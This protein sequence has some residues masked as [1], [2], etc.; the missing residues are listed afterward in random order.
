MWDEAE[1]AS[2]GRSVLR[3]EGFA[4]A[5]VP[6]RLRPPFLPTAGAA[7]MWLFGGESDDAILRG[8][9][10]VLAL[11]V[12][13]SVYAFGAARFDKL[14]GLVAAFLLGVTPFFWTRVP[15]FL[16]EIP[17]L[18]FFAAAV[19]LFYSG[20]YLDQRHFLWSWIACAFAFLT[21]HTAVLF[22]PIVFLFVLIAWWRGGAEVRGRIRSRSF[23]LSPLAG[24]LVFLPWLAR[25]YIAFGDPLA[26]LKR[27]SHQLQ[28][29]LPG[30]AM[31]W[32]F[33]LRHLPS[34]LSLEIGLFVLV[35]IGWALWKRHRFLLHSLLAAAFIVAWFSFYRYKEDR[36][37][38]S[39][40]P[41]LTMIAAVALTKSTARLRPAARGLVLGALLAGTFVV[42]LRVTRHVFENGTTLGYPFFLDAMTFLRE[43]A[44]SGATVLGAN[45]PQIFWYTGL[46][47]VDI[48]EEVELAQALRK[49]EWIVISNFEP[50]Q[51]GYVFPMLKLISATPSSDSAVF[52]D[53][54]CVTAVV[55]SEK[56]LQTL[57]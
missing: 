29:Y 5:G 22:F 14:T 45:V 44:T 51:K 46:H 28:D 50:A 53:Q 54:R 3:G 23:F 13:L 21:R 36:I 24:L 18:G 32:D 41:F 27:A 34:L 48:P 16:C 10:A 52:W 25:E 7:A 20:L 26:G 6:N 17:F 31:P 12:L 30:T 1:Y 39:A 47:A 55:R 8:T 43:H 15:M 11:F 9:T 38:S 40:F 49:S 35:G 33:Y 57:K 42:N 2:I 4:I 56:M 37:V 19:W